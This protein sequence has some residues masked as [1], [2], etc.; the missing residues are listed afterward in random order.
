VQIAVA[1]SVN[2]NKICGFTRAMIRRTIF[3]AGASVG[4]ALALEEGRAFEVKILNDFRPYI[5][6]RIEQTDTAENEKDQCDE[7]KSFAHEDSL[8]GEEFQ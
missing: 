1:A 6:L 4:R 7:A 2:V 5:L 8:S 3:L